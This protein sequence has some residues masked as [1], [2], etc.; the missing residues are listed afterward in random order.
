[1]GKIAAVGPLTNIALAILAYIFMPLAP[2][3]FNFAAYINLIIALFNCLPF[4]P[5]DGAKIFRWNSSI[6]LG[7]LATAAVLWILPPI[8]GIWISIIIAFVMLAVIVVIMQKFMPV[9]QQSQTE[10]R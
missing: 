1:M 10:Y 2:A 6:W 7:I 5:L 8:I 3:F 4:P 9:R